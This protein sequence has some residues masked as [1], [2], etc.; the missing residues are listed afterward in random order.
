MTPLRLVVIALVCALGGCGDESAPTASETGT[1][2]RTGTSTGTSTSA[3][4]GTR[5]RTGIDALAEAEEEAPPS[6]WPEAPLPVADE[7]ARVETREACAAR[8][9]ATLAA[10]VA[11]AIAALGYDRFVEDVCGGLAAVRDGNVAACDTLS[12]SSARNGCRRRLALVHGLPDACPD[13][14]TVSGREPVCL[15]WAARDVGLCRGAA[16]GERERCEAVLA[17]DAR[18][19]RTLPAGI[20]ARC[21]AEVSRYGAALGTE[22]ATSAA[23]EVEAQLALTVTVDTAGTTARPAEPDASPAEPTVVTISEPQLDRGVVVARCGD[24]LRVRIG[25]ARRHGAPLRLDGP[26]EAEL[27]VRWPA[28]ADAEP[29]RVSAATG[30]AVLRLRIPHASDATSDPGGGGT[31]TLEARTPTRGA[32]L[33]GTVELTMRMP[34]G[35]AR[36]TGSFRTFVRDVLGAD[37]DECR[38]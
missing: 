33:A 35:R 27:L 19:C 7:L 16:V 38:R 5:T 28:D 23:R 1:S 15:A 18:R 36:V 24:G 37:A 22:R 11:D 20:R 8:I 31:V 29:L 13:D 2:T 4:T 17:G 34:G 6:L 3:G 10:E 14:A 26:A 32:L 30:D 21:V 25:D 9:R 12:V